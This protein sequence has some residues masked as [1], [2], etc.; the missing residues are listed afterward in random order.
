MDVSAHENLFYYIDKVETVFKRRLM[1]DDEAGLDKADYMSLYCAGQDLSHNSQCA[2]STI[3]NLRNWFRKFIHV[4]YRELLTS[5]EDL[6]D[7]D[8]SLTYLREYN[9]VLRNF[10]DLRRFFQRLFPNFERVNFIKLYNLEGTLTSAS[11][12]NPH[13]RLQVVSADRQDQ[14]QNDRVQRAPLLRSAGRLAPGA[15]AGGRRDALALPGA[16][17]ARLVESV[18]QRPV[19]L[20]HAQGGAAGL[21]AQ[22]RPIARADGRGHGRGR[23]DRQ[24]GGD[25][26]GEPVAVREDIRGLGA[27][28]GAERGLPGDLQQGGLG[29]VH[30]ATGQSIAVPPAEHTRAAGG[31]L[32]DARESLGR[33]RLQLLRIRGHFLQ[34]AAHV[35]GVAAELGRA[36]AGLLVFGRPDQRRERER[37]RGALAGSVR[38]APGGGIP[39]LRALRERGGRRVVWQPLE[40]AQDQD[41]AVRARHEP[42]GGQLAPPGKGTAHLRGK[43]LFLRTGP[44]RVGTR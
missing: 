40:H 39:R 8:D 37:T 35:R 41:Q 14:V 26:P 3:K 9:Q 17:V 2:D 43:A 34:G 15:G 23:R 12:R 18:P 44:A 30:L 13:Q 32:P 31:L 6:R 38:D 10:E 11:V 22:E 19:L 36:P 20:E 4:H 29:D 21:R 16:L 25:L 42:E 5:S 28:Q 33:N 7:Q 27:V 1:G 24:P